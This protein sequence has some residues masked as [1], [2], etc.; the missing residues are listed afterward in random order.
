MRRLKI[1]MLGVSEIKWTSKGR[2]DFY[3]D[4][5]RITGS[6]GPVLKV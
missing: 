2:N 1:N 6:G 3:S 4:E 5:H